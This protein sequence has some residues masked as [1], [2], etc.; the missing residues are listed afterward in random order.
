MNINRIDAKTSRVADLYREARESLLK[1]LENLDGGAFKRK[2]WR[3]EG[4]GGGEMC[5]LRGSVFEKAGVNFSSVRGVISERFREGVPHL[6]PEGEFWACGVSLVV[7]PASPFVPAV[8]MNIRH[9]VTQK[10]W[11]G[12]GADITPVFEDKKSVGKFH[13]AFWKACNLYDP[14]VYPKFSK[15][16]D[17]YFFLHHRGVPRGAGGIFFDLMNSGDFEKD[18]DFTLS[19]PR[20]LEEV[21]SDIVRANMDKSWTREEKQAQLKKRALY[22]EFNLLHDRG[23]RFGLETGANIEALFMSLPPGASW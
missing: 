20:A 3:R 13:K 12:G 11:F 18:L 10:A 7:H 17:D 4:G 21:Y 6:G 19:I 1:T 14:A 15:A 16:C 22:V 9:L 8:H 5:I 23:T 2:K